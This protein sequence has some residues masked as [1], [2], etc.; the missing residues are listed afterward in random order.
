M[1]EMEQVLLRKKF[2]KTQVSLEKEENNDNWSEKNETKS[3]S[4]ENPLTV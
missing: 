2:K 3:A 4:K 1:R